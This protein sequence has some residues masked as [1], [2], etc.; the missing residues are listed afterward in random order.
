MSVDTKLQV[1]N[2]I[3]LVYIAAMLTVGV[4]AYLT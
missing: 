1:I 2:V 4:V 3:V